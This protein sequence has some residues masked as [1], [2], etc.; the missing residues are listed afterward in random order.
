MPPARVAGTTVHGGIAQYDLFEVTKGGGCGVIGDIVA[1]ASQ[2]P[3]GKLIERMPQIVDGASRLLQATGITRR[4]IAA[5]LE[6]VATATGQIDAKRLME[7]VDAIE[8]S[9][10]DLNRQVSEAAILIAELA[11]TN[12]SLARAVGL[13]RIWIAGLGLTALSSSVI[14]LVVIFV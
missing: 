13:H 6:I 14:S 3:W 4:K 7:T 2:V 10:L 5:D 8:E 1:V 11:E 12:R 9:L